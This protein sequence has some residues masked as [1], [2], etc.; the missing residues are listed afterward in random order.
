MFT[1]R[2]LVLG[3]EYLGFVLLSLFDLFLTG[4]IFKFGGIEANGLPAWILRNWHLVGFVIFKF[5]FVA[6]I[7]IICEVIAMFNLSK[8]RL[9]ILGGCAV[10]ALVVVYECVLIFQHID[11][12]MIRSGSRGAPIMSPAAINAPSE[13]YRA[14]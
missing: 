11:S 1:K 6:F 4:Y 13:R 3:N 14:V 5:S 7:I 10:Y 2:D 9:V 12:Q 8:A